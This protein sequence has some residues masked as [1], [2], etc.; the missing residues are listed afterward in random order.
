MT[1][2]H[3]AFRSR[4]TPPDQSPGQLAFGPEFDSAPRHRLFFAIWPDAGAIDRLTKLT[5]LPGRPVDPDRLHVTLHHLGDF[6][7][8]MP[9]SLVPTACLAAATIKMHPFKVTFDRIGGTRGQFLLRAIN[10]LATLLELRHNLSATLTKFS[11]RGRVN[12]VF[13]P[14]MTLSYDFS[15]APEQRID[16]I[17]WTVT[18]FA[19]TESLL[20]K[21]KHIKR[22]SWKIGKRKLIPV[23]C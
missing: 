17:S 21:H 15:D 12:Q 18:H 8:Q 22:G 14:H 20:G 16:P 7:D 10:Q 4:Y 11:L 13:N 23:L 1:P 6:V 9:P 19:L 2:W 5:V 3:D